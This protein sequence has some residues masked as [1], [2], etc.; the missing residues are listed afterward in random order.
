MGADFR[1]Q[2]GLPLD[3]GAEQALSDSRHKLNTSLMTFPHLAQTKKRG[4]MRKWRTVMVGAR[5]TST[6]SEVVQFAREWQIAK[7]I[8][9]S[10][11]SR[12]VA[13]NNHNR[14]QRRLING[15]SATCWLLHAPCGQADSLITQINRPRPRSVFVFFFFCL[16]LSLSRSLPQNTTTLPT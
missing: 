15:L 2:I 4:L 14:S 10:K 5:A 1:W 16:S 9:S 11:G 3:L 8:Q 13:R 7:L 12:I 6:A